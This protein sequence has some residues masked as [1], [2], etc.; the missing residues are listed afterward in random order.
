VGCG[1]CCCCC[2]CCR[3]VARASI[4]PNPHR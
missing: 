4:H 2:C 3:W 1:C